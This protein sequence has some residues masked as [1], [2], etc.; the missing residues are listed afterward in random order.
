MKQKKYSISLTRVDI[1]ISFSHYPVDPW[2]R[3]T[4]ECVSDSSV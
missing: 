1:N 3:L 2:K 4:Y